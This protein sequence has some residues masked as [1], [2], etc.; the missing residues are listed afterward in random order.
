MIIVVLKEKILKGYELDEY[1]VRSLCGRSNVRQPGHKD[2]IRGITIIEEIEGE[3]C[4]DK[5]KKNWYSSNFVV[6]SIDNRNFAVYY[7][8]GLT[9]IKEHNFYRQV[10]KEVYKKEV[11]RTEWVFKDN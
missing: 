7:S 3:L 2:Y 6:F 10:A 8:K 11:I 9:K 5:E 1:D 4:L